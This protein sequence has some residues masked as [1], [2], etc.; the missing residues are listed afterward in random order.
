MAHSPLTCLLRPWER[1]SPSFL[2]SAPQHP[3]LTLITVPTTLHCK[4]LFVCLSP[5]LQKI[6]E[7]E[8]HVS[9]ISQHPNQ[10]GPQGPYTFSS[11]PTLPGGPPRCRAPG[12]LHSLSLQAPLHRTGPETQPT[13]AHASADE[14]PNA[15]LLSLV[16]PWPRYLGVCFHLRSRGESSIWSERLR[17]HAKHLH[18]RCA[19][20]SSMASACARPPQR[21]EESACA[22]WHLTAVLLPSPSRLF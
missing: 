19:H 15:S 3:I 11:A 21:L 5:Q 4:H 7:A 22:N 8:E 10:T 2:S 9:L 17:R 1:A 18:Q 6:P 20:K 12:A 14:G 13:Q 16:C